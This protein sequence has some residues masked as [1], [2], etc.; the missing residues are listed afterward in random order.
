MALPCIDLASGAQSRRIVRLRL[1][2][3]KA[4]V[5]DERPEIVTG[6]VTGKAG[7]LPWFRSSAIKAGGRPRR[8]GGAAFGGN[9]MQQPTSPAVPSRL[10]SRQRCRTCTTGP[11]AT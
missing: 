9:L 6:G 3:V 2:G 1:L 11:R 5:S 4:S 10:T 7:V 8:L